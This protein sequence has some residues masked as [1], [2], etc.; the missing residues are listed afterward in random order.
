MANAPHDPHGW[1]RLGQ[2]A[3]LAVLVA[4][5]LY[6]LYQ[7]LPVLEL[8]ALA[9]L[10]SLIL[11]TLLY[12]LYKLIKVRWL[13]VA[14]LVAA[15]ASFGLIFVTVIIPNI[16]AEIQILLTTLPNYLTTLNA[17]VAKL[18][19]SY[20]ITLNVSQGL[21]QL[22]NV[23]SQLLSSVPVLLN[24]VFDLTLQSFATLIL[25][26]YIAYD[27]DT[28]V[29]SV[30]R[31][32]P[33]RQ[34]PRFNRLLRAMRAR[35]RGWIFGA[36]IAMLFLGISA[37]VGLWIIGIPLALSFGVIAGLF[38]V[39]PYF[40]SIVGTVLPALVAL[41]LSPTKFVL[42]LVLFLVLN[43][44]D[45]HLVQPL[46]MGREV[47]LHPVMVIVTFLVMGKLLGLIGV[48]LAVPTAAIVVTLLDELMSPSP[49]T[50][51]PSNKD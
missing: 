37:A 40:G 34:H 25:A 26:L 31:L 33:R 27:P 36:G 24:Q 13:A 19:Q 4:A 2:G 39:I 50:I 38:E 44:I 3:P 21:E 28:I 23:A 48:I 11:R 32:I 8:I 45:A 9:A 30:T 35:L 43:Q 46:V 49:E 41:T 22:R 7:L 14:I 6:I 51:D 15:I 47:R 12:W 1:S 16:I 17:E 20:G 10:I 18:H 29:G 42:V 5:V